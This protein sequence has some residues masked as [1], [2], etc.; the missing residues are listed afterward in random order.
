MG[1]LWG[2]WVELA[3]TTTGFCEVIPTA[4]GCEVLFLWWVSMLVLA[5]GGTATLFGYTWMVI[6]PPD[7]YGL[8][9]K[10]LAVYVTAG[11]HTF[12]LARPS[13]LQAV[14]VD[15]RAHCAVRS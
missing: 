8:A 13:L 6:A 9:M 11:A 10:W 15:P 7:A 5:V 1:T 4:E 12:G 3:T 14:S 2:G